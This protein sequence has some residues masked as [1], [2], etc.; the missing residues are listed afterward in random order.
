[1]VPVILLAA[2][3]PAPPVEPPSSQG[4]DA[5]RHQWLFGPYLQLPPEDD[6]YSSGEDDF[7]IFGQPRGAA[8]LG[9]RSGD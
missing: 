5:A 9:G 6:D 7:G 4:P 3:G 2:V 8:P 1:M